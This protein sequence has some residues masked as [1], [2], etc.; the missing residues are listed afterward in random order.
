MSNA[1]A[2]RDL[3]ITLPDGYNGHVATFY[4]EPIATDGNLVKLRC[5]EPDRQ[6]LI[7][8]RHTDEVK[9]ALALAEVVARESAMST[10][11]VKLFHLTCQERHLSSDITW[12]KPGANAND[13]SG[14]IHWL[15]KNTRS[16]TNYAFIGE[17]SI[18]LPVEGSHLVDRAL[19]RT[20]SRTQNVESSW[21]LRE[22]LVG[23]AYRALP[24]SIRHDVLAGTVESKSQLE[25]IFHQAFKKVTGKESDCE[26]DASYEMLIEVR[27]KLWKKKAA[28]AVLFTPN[29]TVLPLVQGLR[30][31]S[32]GDL[33]ATDD[34]RFHFV[35]RF[36][37]TFLPALSP[38]ENGSSISGIPGHWY[39][40]E[41]RNGE[42]E[43][44]CFS[45]IAEA[46]DHLSPAES[47]YLS[48][49]AMACCALQ[50]EPSNGAEKAPL[51]LVPHRSIGGPG[52]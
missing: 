19:E 6:H 3:T 32:V 7:A 16:D 50:Q 14:A 42:T 22:S 48:P 34:G 15:Y 20:F 11:K 37:M 30:S 24:E 12:P 39:A 18:S 35:D 5:A 25:Q 40:V 21:S 10:T 4:A 8:W 41:R 45:A 28:P 47:L 44:R 27:N 33:M 2:N 29:E 13:L 51:N 46:I 43:T 9:K 52:F 1:L 26:P 17:F 49:L 23:E 31:S 38:A 36:G